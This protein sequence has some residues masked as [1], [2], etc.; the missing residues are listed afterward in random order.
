M[1]S[2]REHILV[3]LSVFMVIKYVIVGILALQKLAIFEQNVQMMVMGF[4]IA[5]RG[6]VNFQ[7]RCWQFQRYGGFLE[8]TLMG[9]FSE[10]DF[11]KRMRV[12]TSTFHY[13]C[14]LL[15]PILKKKDTHFRESISVERKIA[16][17]LSRLAT[18]NSLQMIGDLFGV[19]LSTTS[20]I[21]RECCKAI[22]I[23]LR[24]LVFK[25][26]TLPWMKEISKGFEALHGI[27]FI[28]GAIDGSHIPILA[29]S[30]DPVAYYC[31]KGYYSC[32]L[33][34][35]VDADCKFWDYDFGWAG[36]IHDWALFQKSEIG[37]KTMRGAF[38]P[39]RFIGDAAYPMRPWFYSPFKGEKEGLSRKKAHWNFI[40]SSTCMA[41]ERAFGILKGRWRILLKRIDMPLS[42]VPDIVTASLCL[43]NLCILENDEFCM[44]WAKDAEREL[45]AEA[46]I[47]LGNMQQTDMFHALESSLREMRELQ[48]GNPQ[49]EDTQFIEPGEE[50]EMDNEDNEDNVASEETKKERQE[51][52]K[53]ILAD[54]TRIHLLLAKS[55]YKNH[56]ARNS[57]IRFE[58]TTH[59][60][61][62]SS[63]DE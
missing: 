62:C 54:S 49:A 8:H 31:H 50:E 59:D 55:Y 18:G 41:V 22:R 52:M 26:P 12:D 15:G 10:E 32:L 61:N 19:G 37:K 4:F 36:R 57:N 44:D 27:P 14:T 34:G 25:K 11:R 39:Y 28:L 40:H 53:E 6:R 20:I 13:L 38:L 46:N 48:R 30:H 23:H 45:Q 56:L 51:K 43:H 60:D 33:Q 21:V 2:R 24:P 63:N 5:Q 3:L 47:S 16:I 58:N 29:P 42:N 7:R 1:D 35:V 17:T 9:S